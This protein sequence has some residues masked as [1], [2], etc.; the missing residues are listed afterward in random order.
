MRG[1]R[2]AMVI[3]GSFRVVGG[4]ILD[5]EGEGFT[6]TYIAVGR[7]GVRFDKTFPKTMAA[8]ATLQAQA[9][10]DQFCG[11]SGKTASGFDIFLWSVIAAAVIDP[12][13]NTDDRINFT[14]VVKDSMV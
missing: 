7:Y 5:I 3:A 4:A 6:V 11:V 14:A 2:A 10:I 9:P 1:E 8:Q 13:V 12:G